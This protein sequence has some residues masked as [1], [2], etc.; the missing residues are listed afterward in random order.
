MT[1]GLGLVYNAIHAARCRMAED[2]EGKWEKEVIFG[3]KSNPKNLEYI[4]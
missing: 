4:R 2:G 3:R 1:T